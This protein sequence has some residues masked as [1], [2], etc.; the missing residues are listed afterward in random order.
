MIKFAICGDEPMIAREL[1]GQIAPSARRSQPS[2]LCGGVKERRW[3]KN[4]MGVLLT[5]KNGRQFYLSA[6]L[7]ILALQ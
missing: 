2:D 6:L 4:I 1:A 5:E 7:N 3:R